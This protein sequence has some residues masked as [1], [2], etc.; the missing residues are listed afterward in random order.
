MEWFKCAGVNEFSL[1]S[2]LPRK[3]HV[4]KIKSLYDIDALNDMDALNAFRVKKRFL[5]K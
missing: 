5:P 1:H 3:C 4:D 2:N